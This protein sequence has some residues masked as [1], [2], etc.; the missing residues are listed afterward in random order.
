MN[1]RTE[2]EETTN[3]LYYKYIQQ[4]FFAVIRAS[5]LSW[6]NST[7]LHSEEQLN[8]GTVEFPLSKFC[9]SFCIFMSKRRRETTSN[10]CWVSPVRKSNYCNIYRNV[11]V[12]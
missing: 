12:C 11:K 6:L 9:R 1:K 3:V 2:W 10:S 8:R 5:Y 7:G 4:A